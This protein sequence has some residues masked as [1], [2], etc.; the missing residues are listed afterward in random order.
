MG[1]NAVDSGVQS[2]AIHQ[3]CE[4]GRYTVPDET[5]VL[6]GRTIE[7]RLHVFDH[8]LHESGRRYFVE[9]GFD[10]DLELAVLIADY[11]QQAKL[12]GACPMSREAIT[13]ALMRDPA[14]EPP[15]AQDGTP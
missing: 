2:A 10:S 1:A 4:L 15:S 8:P 9:A 14:T 3:P 11:R 5:R 6:V 7:D 12:L 13:R